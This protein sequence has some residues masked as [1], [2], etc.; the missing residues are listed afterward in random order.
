MEIKG[1]KEKMLFYVTKLGK[2]R[3][4]DN[5]SFDSH[6]EEH[7]A[8]CYQGTRVELLQH[9]DTWASDLGSEYL[10]W[11]NG[12]A[13]TGKS[14]ISRTVAQIFADKG[15]LGASFFFRRGE[16]DRCHAGF[17]IGTIAT[18][19]VQKVPSLAP[20]IQKAIEADP[21]ISRKAL[22]I[23]FETLVLQPLRKMQ[24]DTQKP[25]RIV[26]VVDALDECDQEEDIGIIIRL[27]P[28]VRHITSVQL[29]FFLSSRP[30]LHIRLGFE[31]IKGKYEVLALHQIPEP[32]VKEDISAF[33]E[34]ELATIRQNYNNRTNV[35]VLVEMAMPLFIFATTVC[36]F[37]RDRRC[38]QPNEQLSKV[39]KYHTKSQLSK[40]D[41]MY[42]SVLNPL[43]VGVTESEKRGIVEEFQQVVGPIIILA[44]PLSATSLDLL[45]GVPEGTV[46]SRTDLLHS[47]LSIPSRAGHPIRLFHLSFRDFLV[48]TEKR[49][50]NPFW[51]NEKD[52][53]GKLATRCL[54]RLSTNKYLKKDICDLQTPERPRADVDR[55]TIDLHLP[56]DIQYT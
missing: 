51:I 41:A 12:M 29:K 34:H 45:L 13:G 19:L 43:L 2:L 16:G 37:I 5:A 4:A 26:I 23:Q 6:D 36:R 21:D 28:Q 48:D 40:L 32:V 33:L 11:L 53:H 46:D 49:E 38:G 18:Q 52:V 56:A 47:V 10:F 24:T 27:L 50:T 44:S 54:Q 35:Q 20:H 17:F 9:I 25:S 42:L 3:S 22:K 55:Q 8:R 15:D 14:T 39:L 1:H 7:N 31:D 30:E